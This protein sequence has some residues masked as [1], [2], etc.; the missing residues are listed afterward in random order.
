MLDAFFVGETSRFKVMLQIRDEL[1]VYIRFQTCIVLPC[2]TFHSLHLM[3]PHTSSPLFYI[4]IHFPVRLL[5]SVFVLF[6]CF[7]TACFTNVP[8]EYLRQIIQI[9]S[10]KQSSSTGLLFFSHSFSLAPQTLKSRR[11]L[12]AALDPLGPRGRWAGRSSCRHG[13]FV[14]RPS[15]RLPNAYSGPRRCPSAPFLP[16]PSPHQT[17]GQTFLISRSAFI[18]QSWRMR[19]VCSSFPH[20]ALIPSAFVHLSC[21]CFPAVNKVFW[22]FQPEL[23][24]KSQF[25]ACV[26]L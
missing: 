1:C 10:L 7:Y 25:A 9:N 16:S 20:G 6:T 24:F 21:Y 22:C 13:L 14:A 5:L 2:L 15:L 12:V 17:P 4:Y 8:S 23:F 3:D 18:Q 11:D 26:G 19:S